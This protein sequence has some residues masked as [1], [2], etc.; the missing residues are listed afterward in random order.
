MYGI[1]ISLNSMAELQR[2]RKS[3]MVSGLLQHPLEHFFNFF[4]KKIED[5]SQFTMNHIVQNVNPKNH[6]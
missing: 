2:N 4:L 6:I 3:K 5:N 1:Q